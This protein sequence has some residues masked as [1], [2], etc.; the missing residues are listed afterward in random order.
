MPNLARLMAHGTWGPLRSV[1]PPITVPAWA[2]MFSGYDPGELCVYGFRNRRPGGVAGAA[3]LVGA[4]AF[5]LAPEP[6]MVTK[7]AGGTLALHGSDVVSAGVVQI[8]SGTSRTTLT[9]QGVTSAAEALGAISSD[10]TS[11]GSRC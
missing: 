8:A 3:E 11:T 1:T 10:A 7:L 6:T 9:A 2:C 4:A 5:S